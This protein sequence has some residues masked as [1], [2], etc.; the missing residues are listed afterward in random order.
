MQKTKED[1]CKDKQQREH[2]YE[3]INTIHFTEFDPDIV[4]NLSIFSKTYDDS[5]VIYYKVDD[6]NFN[7]APNEESLKN[8]DLKHTRDN[9]QQ[10][11]RRKIADCI[12]TWHDVCNLHNKIQK[13]NN[14]GNI[15]KLAF[16]TLTLS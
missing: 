7:K 11:T 5:L 10:S 8:L 6:P 4:F 12:R 1:R 15:K 13:A 14:S 16:I 2:F 3:F 9:L